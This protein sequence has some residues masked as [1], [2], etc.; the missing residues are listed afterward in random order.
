MC[1]CYRQHSSPQSALQ[2][3]YEG[4]TVVVYP[5]TYSGEGFH[6]LTESIVI[7]GT[8][9][10]TRC[11]DSRMARESAFEAVD[12]GLI[13]GLG[14]IKDLNIGIHS[15]PVWH[16]ALRNNAKIKPGIPPLAWKMD[17]KWQL[18]SKTE[19]LLRCLLAKAI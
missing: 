2:Q 7:R 14:Y 10:T 9:Y 19:M 15:F 8:V 13:L 6:E 5:G 3:C 18:E 17:G 16:S 1:V 11:K 4:D 12:R